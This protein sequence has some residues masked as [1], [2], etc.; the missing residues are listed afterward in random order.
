MP[1]FCMVMCFICVIGNQVLTVH[2]MFQGTSMEHRN[3]NL[4]K[5]CSGGYWRPCRGKW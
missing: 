5:A 4:V 2:D 1:W 3:V